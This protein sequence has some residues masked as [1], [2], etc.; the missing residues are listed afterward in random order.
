MST[1]TP[2]RAPNDTARRDD[3]RVVRDDLRDAPRAAGVRV[4]VLVPVYQDDGRLAATLASLRAQTVPFAL[5][6]V[7]DGSA[8]PL[9]VS[10]AAAP[11]PTV[12]LRLPVNRG[13]EAALNAG[14]TAIRRAGVPYVARLDNGDLCAPDRLARQA[15]HLDAHPDVVLLGS[16]VAWVDDAGREVFCVRPPTGHD[17]IVRAFAHTVPLIHPTVMFRTAVLE[18]VG[19]YPTAY[20]A[21]EDYA[22][23]WRMA[24]AGRVA[25]LRD[26][27]VTTRFDG[28]GISQRRR[29]RQLASRWRIQREHFRAGDPLAWYGLAKTGALR[30]LPYRLIVALKRA[31]TRG[32]PGPRASAPPAAPSPL[33]A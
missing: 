5:V 22:L 7:D 26:V 25:C 4:A 27:L 2:G 28:A 3:V 1:A 15:T 9:D 10:P 31:R 32:R 30:V 17:A 21:A 24:G 12:H 33:P 11:F 16:S 23:F 8:V 20:P 13:I 19:A 18:V 29:A 6:V 14:L